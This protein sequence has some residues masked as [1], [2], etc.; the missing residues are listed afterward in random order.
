MEKETFFNKV[1][2]VGSGLDLGATL[3]LVWKLSGG[4]MVVVILLILLETGLFLGSLY[5]LKGLIDLIA[6]Q[7]YTQPG[8]TTLV[9]H[10]IILAGILAVMHNGLKSVTVFYT[11]KQAAIVAEHMN[12][13]IHA[14]A[15]QMDLAFYESPAY[16]D[17]LQRAKE[18]GAERPNAVLVSLLDTLK[19]S[20][21]L[22]GIASVMVSI[23]WILLPLLVLFILPTLLVRIQYSG[24][25]HDLRVKNTGLERQSNYLSQLITTEAP[26]KEIRIYGL[27]DYLKKRYLAI[28]Y[29]LLKQKLQIASKRTKSEVMTHLLASAG[30]FAC[31]YFMTISA[32]EGQVGAGDIAIFMIVF[33]QV[34]HLLQGIAVGISVIYQNNIYVQSIFELFAWKD[35]IPTPHTPALALPLPAKTIELKDV[36]FTYPYAKHKTLEGIHL[37]LPYGKIIALVGMNGAGKSTLIK[38][39]TG[40]YRPDQGE[41]LWNNTP[42]DQ[43]DMAEY[44][45]QFGVVFQDFTRFHATVEDNVRFGNIDK[46]PVREEEIQNALNLT[47]ASIFVQQFEQGMYTMMGR[48]FEDGKEVSI[49]QWQKLATARALYNDGHYVILDEASSALDTHAEWELFG[50]LREKIEGRG[51]LLI[52]HRYSTVRQADYIYVLSEGKVLEEGTPDH[53][54]ARKGAYYDLFKDEWV[55]QSI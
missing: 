1:K 26:A 40:L 13:E 32:I 10:Q 14:T 48:Q 42:I 30:F 4:L 8:G 9:I 20:L 27:G 43:L 21:S 36:H 19:N 6:T 15:I 50:A 45:K 24:K 22:L 33:P 53:L 11:E 34:F 17:L 54:M 3:R 12:D 49:G 25:L 18:A 16:F 29:L 35:K 37:T 38:M 41:V 51:A 44:R 46:T 55:T 2:K 31:I 39:L 5:A 52:S 23:D 47:G 7:Q 28:R